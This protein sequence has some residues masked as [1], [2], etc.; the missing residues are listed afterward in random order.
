MITNIV[1]F[2]AY[3]AATMQV[4]S[5]CQL[6]GAPTAVV[7]RR[8]QPDTR[9]HGQSWRSFRS[10]AMSADTLQTNIGDGGVENSDHGYSALVG[11]TM[12]STWDIVSVIIYFFLVMGTGIYVSRKILQK[13]E[14]LLP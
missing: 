5:Y 9:P 8:R 10:G 4:A 2:G 7:G 12:L 11:N 6:Y 13:F 14:T 1:E 3:Q